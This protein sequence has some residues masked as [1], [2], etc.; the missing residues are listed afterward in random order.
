MRLPEAALGEVVRLVLTGQPGPDGKP[1]KDTEVSFRY[2]VG[3]EE[4]RQQAR[5]LQNVRDAQSR[6]NKGSE[7][8]AAALEALEAVRSGALEARDAA[9]RAEML[10]EARAAAAAEAAAEAAERAAAAA[11]ELEARLERAVEARE[12]VG[13]AAVLEAWSSAPSEVEAL[14]AAG[15]PAA[16]KVAAHTHTQ[17]PS[18]PLPPLSASLA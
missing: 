12:R 10:E 1:L 3:S 15:G 2:G 11:R 13:L 14:L 8:N 7:A 17:T 9:R 5:C 16:A 18:H 6:L 4:A